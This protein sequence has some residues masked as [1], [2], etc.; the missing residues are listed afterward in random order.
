MRAE[1]NV[2]GLSKA[3]AIAVVVVIVVAAVAALFLTGGLMGG[4][5]EP[6]RIGV[7]APLTGAP[8]RAGKAM[9][10]A[11]KMAE[12]D[13]NAAGGLLGRKVEI[14][15]YDDEDKPE[16]GKVVAERA[17]LQDK[18][19]ALAGIFRSEVAMVVAEV[20]AEQKIPLVVGTAQTPKL[21]QLVIDNYDKYKYVFR[22]TTN[23]T[24]LGNVLTDFIMDYL[25]KK[26]NVKKIGFLQEDVLWARALVEFET[27]RLKARGF[28][29][30]T[31]V[32]PLGVTDIPELREMEAWG[33]DVIFPVFSSDNGYLV[34][35]LYTEQ[36]IDAILLGV[37]NPI[38][39][40]EAW[41]KTEGRAEYET[42]AVAAPVVKIP[43][44]DQLV[45]WT[46]RYIEKYGPE[47]LN[48]AA[49]TYEALQVIF[50]AIQKAGSTDPDKLVKAL[51]ENEFDTLRGKVKFTKYHQH[52]SW[53]GPPYKIESSLGGPVGQWQLVNGEPKVVVVWPPTIGNPDNWKPAPWVTVPRG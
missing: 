30:K 20:A 13:I 51:E 6:I 18:V 52:M 15:V 41:E 44:T 33:A 40:P 5:E 45:P 17:I 9:A 42:I 3:A 1:N 29:V 19:V 4:E 28:E 11:A 48:Q 38:A 7:L 34:T 31:W 50:Q 12:E 43:V 24:A 25:A 10:N 26:Y 36:K 16:V 37:N 8:A 47:A 39:S 21:T 49:D 22:S 53:L 14:L 46:E 2:S 27:K 32:V 35:R 23:A